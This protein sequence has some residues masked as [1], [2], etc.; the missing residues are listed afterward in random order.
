MCIGHI[1]EVDDYIVS[2]LYTSPLAY[3]DVGGG[4]TINKIKS[5]IDN[6]FTGFPRV[7]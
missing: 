5:F 4:C 1:I 2:K 3:L 6:A 7:L